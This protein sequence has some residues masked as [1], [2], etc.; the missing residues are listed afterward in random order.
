MQVDVIYLLE[1]FTKPYIILDDNLRY[2]LET[3]KSGHEY[4]HA[5]KID[6]FKKYMK[7]LGDYEYPYLIFN[8]TFECPQMHVVYDSNTIKLLNEKGLHIFLTEN[9]MKYNG[10]RKHH[11]NLDHSIFLGANS[12]TGLNAGIFSDPRCGQLDSVQDLIRNND[13][14]NVTVFLPEHGV[15]EA[16]P[17]YD[18]FTIKYR[19]L[20]LENF[21]QT[22]DIIPDPKKDIEY[23]FVNLNW[24][25]EPFRHVVASYLSNYNSKISWYYTSTEESFKKNIWFE[26]S[27]KLLLG[28]NKLNSSAPLSVDIPASDS[29]K[30]NGNILDRFLLPNYN[31]MPSIS[32]HP[33]SN[34]FCSIVSESSYLDLTYY[35]SDKTMT[36]IIN[37][38]PFVIVGTPYALKTL[39]QMGF[40]TFDKYWDESYDT[41]TDHTLRME[42]IFNVIDRI[43]SLTTE[44]LV[45]MQSDMQDILIYNKQHIKKSLSYNEF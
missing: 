18:N 31:D 36:S 10:D 28:F 12:D 38:M 14:T 20:F 9:L 35:V 34:V 43:A 32:S 23:T 40:K 11:S 29:I 21:N 33:Y 45:R 4:F 22:Q 15:A 42:K 7:L 24:R 37:C 39:K 2:P 3:F 8:N 13:L 6:D 25:Y 44:E 19:D 17:R 30:I 1:N 41:E 26:P 27:D 5:P 16:L